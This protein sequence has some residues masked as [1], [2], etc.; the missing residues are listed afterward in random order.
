MSTSYVG[1]KKHNLLVSDLSVSSSFRDTI[2]GSFA[3]IYAHF[4]FA[5][6]QLIVLPL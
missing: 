4:S 2:M 6:P 5:I 1:R 3:L